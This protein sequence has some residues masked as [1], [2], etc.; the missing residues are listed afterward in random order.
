MQKE[1][2]KMPCKPIKQVDKEHKNAYPAVQHLYFYSN[3]HR[4][5]MQ[6]CFARYLQ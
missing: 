5:T 1:V 2:I 6:T 3:E 4:T